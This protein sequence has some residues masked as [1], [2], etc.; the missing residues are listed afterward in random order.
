MRQEISPR[1]SLAYIGGVAFGRTSR[2]VEITY[3]L[4][5]PDHSPDSAD[6]VSE[7]PSTYDVGPMVAS[8]DAF[9]WADRSNLVPGMRLQ[10]IEGG[11]LI[12]P[13]LG[14]AWKF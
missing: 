11:W 10:A 1:F 5:S 8:R 9:A 4:E 14:L 3:Q 2:E 7:S 6:R 13:A 12:R